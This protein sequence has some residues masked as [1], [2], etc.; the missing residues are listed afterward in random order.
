MKVRFPLWPAVILFLACNFLSAFG[1]APEAK[2]PG[3][4]EPNPNADLRE[5]TIYVPFNK[6]RGM[7]EAPGR[8]VFLPVSYTHLTLPTNREV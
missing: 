4:D 8:G 5:R 7:F 2:K 6:L 1:Q 3:D